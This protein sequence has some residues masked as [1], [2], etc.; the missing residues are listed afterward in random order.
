MAA[1]RRI[2]FLLAFNHRH[3]PDISIS[4]PCQ[5]S[6]HLYLH[7]WRSCT[8][9]WICWP[10]SLPSSN[11]IKWSSLFSPS[12]H[13]CATVTWHLRGSFQRGPNPPH[14]FF[15]HQHAKL[16][17][18][19]LAART[20]RSRVSDI[21]IGGHVIPAQHRRG[22]IADVLPVRATSLPYWHQCFASTIIFNRRN[23]P[24]YKCKACS[25]NRS[26]CGWRAS[27]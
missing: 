20:H 2:S 18:R 19:R 5:V 21:S 7:G 23:C 16:S 25:P 22:L 3:R 27:D 26:D 9:L 1:S 14:W 12:S 24:M 13:V 11:I 4:S 10:L 8:L 6:V 15:Q 17:H